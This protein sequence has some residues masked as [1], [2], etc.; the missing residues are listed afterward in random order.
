MSL[1]TE[2]LSSLDESGVRVWIEHNRLICIPVRGELTEDQNK[3]LQQIEPE[4]IDALTPTK[5]HPFGCKIPAS[6]SRIGLAPLTFRQEWLWNMEGGEYWVI[7][8]SYIINGQLDIDVL[9]ESVDTVVRRHE[10]LRTRFIGI[11]SLIRQQIDEPI[12][13]QLEVVDCS[14]EF[15]GADNKASR[16]L[17]RFYNEAENL[18]SGSLFRSILLKLDEHK[19]IFAIAIHHIVT[20]AESL[21]VI[22]KELL[23]LYKALVRGERASLPDISMQC[24]DYAIW[25]RSKKFK[26]NEEYWQKRLSGAAAI[27][28]PI[29]DGLENVGRRSLGMQEIL[30]GQPLSSA[31]LEL[32]RRE[33][34][35]QAMVVLTVYVSLVSA[36]YNENDLLI[37]FNI[38]GRQRAEHVN[39]TGYFTHPLFLRVEMS[40]KETFLDLLRIVSEEFRNAYKFSDFGKLVNQVPQLM[41]GTYFQWLSSKELMQRAIVEAQW[42]RDLFAIEPFTVHRSGRPGPGGRLEFTNLAL[43]LYASP[44]GICGNVLYRAD[45]FKSSTMLRFSQNFR[46]MAECIVRNPLGQVRSFRFQH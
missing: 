35:L 21:F 23:L 43:P 18:S 8:D 14:D 17:E 46:C 6:H 37:P 28:W 31:L 2:V 26:W 44:Q 36:V 27:E 33:R 45:L 20:D 16:Y 5:L 29:D 39:M 9:C 41:R 4:I 3:R 40:G 10:S 15:E 42:N 34:T 30:F 12:A 24:A 19:H 13:R 32:A 7:T 11:D 38:T 1:I 25:Q 22:F